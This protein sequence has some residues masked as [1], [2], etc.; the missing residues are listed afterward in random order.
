MLRATMDQ[1]SFQLDI[2]S[3]ADA[4]GEHSSS[5]THN[6]WPADQHCA[7]KWAEERFQLPFRLSDEI[8][9]PCHP[10]K[11]QTVGVL[12]QL[13]V[14]R[15]YNAASA[16]WMKEA[17]IDCIK[18][19]TKSGRTNFCFGA[20]VPCDNSRNVFSTSYDPNPGYCNTEIQNWSLQHESPKGMDS[21]QRSS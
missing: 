15:L 17:Y 2:M 3:L 12:G 6:I 1:G 18:V 5:K 19:D 16:I 20:N 7:E 14:P 4:L 8:V 9:K 13:S 10:R 21:T 11:R